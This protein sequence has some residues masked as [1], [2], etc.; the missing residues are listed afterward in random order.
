MAVETKQAALDRFEITERLGE[1]TYGIVYKATVKN[2]SPEHVVALKKIKTD[3]NDEGIPATTIRELSL[4]NVCKHPCIVKL[5]KSLFVKGELW[6]VFEYV[7]N[8]L[9]KYLDNL[10]SSL[11]IKTLK[12]LSY[13][14][15][16]GVKFCHA[17]RILHRDL[18]PQNILISENQQLKIADFGLGLCYIF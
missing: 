16:E 10:K 9:K 3:P 11:N 1:G 2:S 8:D 17:R 15:I 6:L 13:M 5:E 12:I 4:L 7:K 14:L 18:K